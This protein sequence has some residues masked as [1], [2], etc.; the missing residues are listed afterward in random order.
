MTLPPPL[1]PP[2]RPV[3]VWVISGYYLFS[4]IF[5]VVSLW[6]V[7]SGLI[8]L[9][10]GQRPYFNSLTGSDYVCTFLILVIKLVAATTL[11]FRRRAAVYL[12]AF[13]LLAGLAFLIYQI[14]ARHYMQTV[15]AIALPG[16]VV[17]WGVSVAVIIY[18]W[19]LAK[20]GFLR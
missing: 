18:A 13:G 12:F 6:L 11:F 20:S 16:V 8:P 1:P 9:L 14:V 4:S 15:G 2:A 19:N 3:F 17:G 7:Y 5:A 10:P